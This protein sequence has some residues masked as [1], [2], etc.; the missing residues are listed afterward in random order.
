MGEP[1][2]ALQ[3]P[4]PQA[5]RKQ[6]SEPTIAMERQCPLV[7]TVLASPGGLDSLENRAGG[8]T[9]LDSGLM[10]ET[11]ATE[12]PGDVAATLLE[13]SKTSEPWERPN[14][15]PEASIVSKGAHK[16]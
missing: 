14:C 10:K 13:T 16:G 5:Q 4:P 2:H 7:V 15:E 11:G 12:K 6:A 3:L 1:R 8:G 9:R